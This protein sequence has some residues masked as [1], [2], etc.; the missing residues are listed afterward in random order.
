VSWIDN[1]IRLWGRW[2]VRAVVGVIGFAAVTLATYLIAH[3]RI[4]SGFASYDDEGYML[5]ALKSF[6]NHG[7]LYDDVF[8]QYGPFYYEFWGGIFDLFGISVTHDGGRAVTLVAW[9]LSS[10]V[11]GLAT[12][13]LVG[14][15]LLGLAT[16]I[17]V[18][19]AL[20][21]LV[22]EPM[23]PGGLI[24]L[25]LAAILAIACFVRERV[26]VEAMAMLGGAVAAL[27]LVKINL[28]VFAFAAVALVAV[29]G[30]PALSRSR[31]ARPLVEI[32]F[33]AV[34]LL[35]M[36]SKAGESWARH[37][38]L[39]VAVA[40]LA[41]VIVLRAREDGRRPTAE[42]WWFLSGLVAV[43]LAVVIAIVASGTS[44]GGLIQGVIEQPLSLSDAFSLPLE[45]SSRTYW[46]DLIALAGAGTYWYVARGRVGPPSPVW[47]AVGS[48][49]AIAVGAEMMLSVV[50][51]TVLFDLVG[52]S[53]F[54]IEMLAF[55][56]VALIPAPGAGSRET[57]FART[58][59]P[60]LAVLQA[61]H[62]FPVAGSQL[63]WSAFL[64]IP[65]GALCVA[66][67]VRGLAASLE[68]Q[69]ERQGLAA[70]AALA[71]LVL[72]VV[73]VNLQLRE[74]IHE[75]RA[76]HDGTVPLAL[77]GAT[78]LHVGQPEAETYRDVSAAIERNCEAFLTLPGLG[79]FYI[80]TDQE[81][82]TGLNATAWTELFDEDQQR[83]VIAE[84]ENI[85]GLCL[86]RNIPASEGWS[87]GP[88]TP[89]PLVSYLER[90]FEPIGSW[91][92]YTLL[93]R[94]G[95]ARETS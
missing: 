43:G 93:K 42:L 3:P 80:W 51:R 46:F 95:I 29:T 60:P 20:T 39:H 53:G 65:V 79:S 45:L 62:A 33:V 78:S 83:Q 38:A 47:V 75:A 76:Y 52:Y 14:S 17:L 54:P 16:Q 36:I 61:L 7:S 28:G 71:A 13:R 85:P 50:G 69:R 86:L 64:L 87:G 74:P 88:V 9:V 34:P 21:A 24:C 1:A 57:S 73:V 41:V 4:F 18:F 91:G 23:H 30:Y 2:Q 90:G 12:W 26:S 55:A 68:S 66:N 63:S 44:P 40:A 94:S 5:T 67:G 27:A 77:H 6:V 49:L 35:L 8:S 25:L 92:D 19:G 11:V 70:L 81:P 56:W 48:L 59:L 72:A 10:L 82:P 32:G 84:T 37:Y 31:W 15:L 58:L 89:G 22:N